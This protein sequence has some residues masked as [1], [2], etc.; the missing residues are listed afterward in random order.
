[1]LLLTTYMY[2]CTILWC[3]LSILVRR[4]HM[5]L[6]LTHSN[7]LSFPCMVPIKQLFQMGTMSLWH[8]KIT[9]RGHFCMLYKI[10]DKPTSF[11]KQVFTVMLIFSIRFTSKRIQ[12]STSFYCSVACYNTIIIIIIV[13]FRHM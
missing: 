4:S 8:H 6:D 7:T 10:I 11:V 3:T 5:P 2:T 1:M 13:Y 12:L 9:F